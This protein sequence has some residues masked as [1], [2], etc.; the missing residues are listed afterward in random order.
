MKNNTNVH[1]KFI[2]TKKTNY[3]KVNLLHNM[4]IISD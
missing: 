3:K 2:E 4:H 1:Y